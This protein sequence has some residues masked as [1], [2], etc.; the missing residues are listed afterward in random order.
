MAAPVWR[1]NARTA[2]RFLLL[3]AAAVFSAIALASLLMPHRM[4]RQ[5]GYELTSVDA[6]SEFRA[7][8]VGVWLATAVLLIV[9]AVRVHSL[10]LGDLAAL[11]ILGQT[12]GRILSLAID[13]VP[14]ARI[15]P[16]FALEL[17][18]GV[19]ILVIRPRIPSA[20]PAGGA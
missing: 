19:A 15:W 3:A 1:V 12:L 7:V 20:D 13:G 8:Y 16:F 4:A 10:L 6:L 11:L 9:A 2:R 17:V 5:L 18:G 14:S